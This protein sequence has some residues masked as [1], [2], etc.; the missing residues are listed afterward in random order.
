MNQLEQIEAILDKTVDYTSDPIKIHQAE[1]VTIFLTADVTSGNGVFTVEV[2]ADGVNWVAYNKL[3]D[4][5]IN[6]NAQNLT[7]V[8]SK[9]LNS[10]TTVFV[11]LSPEDTFMFMRMKVD[12]T[13][14]GTYNAIV[15]IQR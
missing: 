1:K 4:N 10:D 8:A 2:S 9:T 6:S 11:S 12:Q 7:R 5:I 15:L 13:T 3:I 14:D